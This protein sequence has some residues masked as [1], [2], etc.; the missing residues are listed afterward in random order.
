MAF[1]DP[2]TE[3]IVYEWSKDSES[4]LIAT[5]EN[6]MNIDD[7]LSEMTTPSTMLTSSHDGDIEMLN[8]EKIVG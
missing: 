8:T 4:D 2:I 1:Y 3:S 5:N 7:L 6:I